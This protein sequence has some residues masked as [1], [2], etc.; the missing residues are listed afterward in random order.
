M[1]VDATQN[2]DS[3]GV[4]TTIEFTASYRGQAFEFEAQTKRDSE[5]ITI[6]QLRTLAIRQLESR[7]GANL[8]ALDIRISSVPEGFEYEQDK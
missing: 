4:L 3:N 5:D 8:S 1:S 6:G 2:Q 7:L